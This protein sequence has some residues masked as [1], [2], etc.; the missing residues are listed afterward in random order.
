M[1]LPKNGSLDDIKV[2]RKKYRE[3]IS[4]YEQINNRLKERL[5]NRKRNH[6]VIPEE[7][8][9][10]FFDTI[11]LFETVESFPMGIYIRDATNPAGTWHWGYELEEP[12][13][14]FGYTKETHPTW[15]ATRQFPEDLKVLG[16]TYIWVTDKEYSLMMAQI[17]K[18]LD[19]QGVFSV[20][21]CTIDD[22]IVYTIYAIGPTVVTTMEN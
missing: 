7:R 16:Q 6:A 5:L 9:I 18:I 3:L 4:T 21:Q 2:D 22:K 14:G 8:L 13:K 15:I 12:C 11:G 1:E 19:L 10:K 20:R 17:T